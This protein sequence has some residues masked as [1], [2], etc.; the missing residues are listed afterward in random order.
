MGIAIILGLLFGSFANVVIYRVP[1][2]QSVV[3]PGSQCPSC[4]KP[5][6]AW[7]NLPVLSWLL[8]RGRSS[9]CRTRIS[10]RYPLIEL[11]GGALAAAVMLRVVYANYTT[12]PLWIALIAF[13]AFTFL[14]IGLLCALFIDLEHM[15]LPDSITI[16][17]TL[18]GFATIWFRPE[19]TWIDSLAGAAIGFTM[20]WLPFIFLYEKVRGQPGMGLGD[21][22]LVMLAGAWFGWQGAVFALLAGSVQAT[23]VM[24]TV[25]GF[26]GK[27]EEPDGVRKQRE[28]LLDAIEAAE[29]EEREALE[30]EFA[31]DPAFRPDDDVGW[32]KARLAFGPFLVL[33]IL[34]YMLLGEGLIWDTLLHDLVFL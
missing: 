7:N 5:I 10:F 32:G 16:G 21:A 6:P 1:L 4:G 23:I 33:A 15:L 34:E 8:L 2:G 24:L 31:E 12:A 19:I 18:L 13:L 25:L 22:K 27:I 29:G 30:R 11:L 17:G 26:S 14:A 3:Y 28:E 9:C 20:I